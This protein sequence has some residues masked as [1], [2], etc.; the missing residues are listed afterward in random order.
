MKKIFI[1]FAFFFIFLIIF[2]RGAYAWKETDCS[3]LKLT[4]QNNNYQAYNCLTHNYGNS[5]AEFLDID[6]FNGSPYERI[7]IRHDFFITSN[8]YWTSDWAYQT[9]KN[10]NLKDLIHLYQLGSII[11]LDYNETKLDGYGAYYKKYETSLGTGF[12]I[13]RQDRSSTFSLGYF[14]ENINKSID[15]KLIKDLYTSINIPGIIKATYSNT[16]PKKYNSESSSNSNNANESFAD[17]CKNSNLGDLSKEV[18]ELCI[19]ELSLK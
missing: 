17:F 6:N 2:N 12:I 15:V 19:E 16:N 11:N 10:E 5:K 3:N 14:T 13:A 4:F 8:V 7:I 1:T 18:A 9:L